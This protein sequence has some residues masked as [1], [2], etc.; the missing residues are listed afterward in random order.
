MI[1]IKFGGSSLRSAE[2]L[3]KVA[4]I[5]VAHAPPAGPWSWSPR[6]AR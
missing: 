5:I 3:A 6:W 2:A 4:D 1:V